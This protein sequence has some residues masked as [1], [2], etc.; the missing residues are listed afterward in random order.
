M[1]DNNISEVFKTP[2][3]I[4]LNTHVASTTENSFSYPLFDLH[5]IPIYMNNQL[6]YYHIINAMLDINK[7]AIKN[8]L[9]DRKALLKLIN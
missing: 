7:V 2:V 1:A 9:K 5:L 8:Q 4:N 6:C 3:I